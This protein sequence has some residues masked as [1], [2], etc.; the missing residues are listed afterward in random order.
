MYDHTQEY[1][2]IIVKCSR[3]SIKNTTSI[4]VDGTMTI[5]MT[6]YTKRIQAFT[7]LCLPKPDIFPGELVCILDPKAFLNGAF[8]KEV[9]YRFTAHISNEKSWLSYWNS[10]IINNPANES[11]NMRRLQPFSGNHN[12][13]IAI[14]CVTNQGTVHQRSLSSLKIIVCPECG[15]PRCEYAKCISCGHIGKIPE[16]VV[17]FNS[18][19]DPKNK[20]LPVKRHILTYDKW[21]KSTVR[22][23]AKSYIKNTKLKL[24]GANSHPYNGIYV[25]ERFTLNKYVVQA[26]LPAINV[27]QQV[28]VEA[29]I[30]EASE[31]DEL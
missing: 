1:P 30:A 26:L 2:C 24:V 29:S 15:A 27:R 23:K 11:K 4:I 14:L 16:Y 13:D 5:S 19:N 17:L 28:S 18:S 22:R 25:L 6:Y 10:H 31:G 3:I 7:N 21:T 9:R 12:S 20:Y 8:V